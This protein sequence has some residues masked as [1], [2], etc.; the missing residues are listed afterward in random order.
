MKFTVV[1]A[2]VADLQLADIWLKA[3]DRQGVADAFN[4]IEASLKFDAH[5][6]G[7]QHAS[8]WR[9]VVLPPL[10]ITFPVS[11]ADRLVRILSVS[12]RP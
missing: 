12:Y 4:R 5:L 11:E 9:V 3:A 2:P 7:R 1:N 10:A 8:G 6:K